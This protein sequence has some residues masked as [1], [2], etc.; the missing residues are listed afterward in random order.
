MRGYIVGNSVGVN[1]DE[2]IAKEIIHLILCKI[3]DE[4]FTAPESMVSFRATEDETD[5]AI[6]DRIDKLFI[7]VKAK[8]K[9]G[10][11]CYL[12]ELKKTKEL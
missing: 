2:V 12:K 11:I 3:Y 6:K 1:R 9:D 10:E 5:E 8:Y 4:R 7:K